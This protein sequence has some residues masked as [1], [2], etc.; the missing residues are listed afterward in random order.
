MVKGKKIEIEPSD[1]PAILFCSW[2]SSISEFSLE[3]TAATCKIGHDILSHTIQ[4]SSHGRIFP[5]NHYVARK[6]EG[7]RGRRIYA[8]DLSLLL[9]SSFGMKAQYL[10]RVTPSVT[11]FGQNDRLV[12]GCCVQPCQIEGANVHRT[13]VTAASRNIQFVPFTATILLRYIKK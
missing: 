6:I 13:D 9:T 8:N 11:I 4:V 5:R 1:L 3:S 12:I 2:S 7:T 10:R